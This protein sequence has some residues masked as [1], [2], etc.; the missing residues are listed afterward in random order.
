MKNTLK[1]IYIVLPMAFLPLPLFSA[2]FLRGMSRSYASS[3]LALR[4]S[5][6]DRHFK[7][8]RE[9]IKALHQEHKE[10]LERLQ[11]KV[12]DIGEGALELYNK[13]MET[14]AKLTKHIETTIEETLQKNS[15]KNRWIDIIALGTFIGLFNNYIWDNHLN[16]QDAMRNREIQ[17]TILHRIEELR[18]YLEGFSTTLI[19]VLAAN[20]KN[21]SVVIPPS[22]P[23]VPVSSPS[24]DESKKSTSITLELIGKK[25]EELWQKAQLLA[26]QS[27]SASQVK[28]EK[29][30]LV[31]QSRSAQ[32][33]AAISMILAD[34]SNF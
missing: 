34:Q 7:V 10:G 30:V 22:I 18:A 12:E 21:K 29:E 15:R 32:V 6:R 1:K 19:Q 3:T 33:D 2:S 13:Q 23:S 14:E 28:E 11:K 8:L 16:G 31:P 25:T 5:L 20:N 27:F 4:S 17:D 26:A 24:E 9:E